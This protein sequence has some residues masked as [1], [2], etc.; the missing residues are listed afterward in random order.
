MASGPIESV[1]YA[2]RRFSVDGEVD[3]AIALPGFMSEVKPNGD[4]T[5]RNVMSR[6]VG[7]VNTLPL[8]MDDA[9]GDREFLQERLDDPEFD[10]FVV[11]LVDGTVINGNGKIVEDPE[12]S[13]KE[14][15]MEVSLHGNVERQGA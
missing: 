11:T 1:V 15:T 5:F 3:A 2:G 13:T 6:R 10:D 4:S 9:R 12:Q 14:N 7:R 8:I